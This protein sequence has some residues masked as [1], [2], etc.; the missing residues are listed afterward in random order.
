MRAND[1]LL[2]LLLLQHSNQVRNINIISKLLDRR[3]YPRA[4]AIV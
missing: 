1:L 3:K 4:S 2:L